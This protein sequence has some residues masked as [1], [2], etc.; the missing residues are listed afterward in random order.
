M[1]FTSPHGKIPSVTSVLTWSPSA[2]FGVEL[3]GV[4]LSLPILRLTTGFRSIGKRGPH[5]QTFRFSGSSVVVGHQDSRTGGFWPEQVGKSYLFGK[6]RPA[7]GVIRVARNLAEVR[8]WVVRRDNAQSKSCTYAPL[9][10]IPRF[11][12]PNSSCGRAENEREYGGD[13]EE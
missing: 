4:S 2:H 1:G 7:R 11:L 9:C 5:G 10:F 8:R 3:N 6:I 13:N 12:H